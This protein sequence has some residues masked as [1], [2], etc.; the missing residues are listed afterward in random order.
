MSSQSQRSVQPWMK[1]VAGTLGGAAVVA[2]VVLAF[3]WPT[4]TISIHNVSLAITGSD[5]N[6]SALEQML[7]TKEPG[8]FTFV[9]AVSRDDAYDRVAARE[10]YGAI[11]VGEPGQ[12]TEVI[13][14]SGASPVVANAL[15]GL[16]Q[17]LQGA[18]AAQVAAAGGDPT[19]VSVTTTN[20]APLPENDPTGSGLA[21]S[22]FPLTLGSLVGAAV[23]GFLV[24]G[25]VRRIF[26]LVGFA[27]VSGLAL[28]GILG[29]WMGFLEGGYLVNAM[30]IGMSILATSSFVVGLFVLLGRPG[31][32]L[33]AGFTML[34][35]NPLAAAALPWQ[36]IAEPWGQFGQY[37]VP[38]ATA[39]LIR[40]VNYFPAANVW[41][42][43]WILGIWAVVGLG[44]LTV[45]SFVRRQKR[46]A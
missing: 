17:Q 37:L 1:V 14:A 44:L 16:A 41:A 27:A 33:G 22:A 35:A 11:S 39:T 42:Q 4:R 8:M 18:L 40:T 28:S 12:P 6:T 38:G 32:G 19:S 24:T 21:A 10:T 2:L 34:I 7:E 13:I 29:N 20:V 45:G 15:S 3:V 5:R 31:F 26:A 30:A 9:Q 25:F 23:A 43:W 36:F 46:A